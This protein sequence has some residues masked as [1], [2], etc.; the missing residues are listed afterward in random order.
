MAMQTSFFQTIDR[1]IVAVH[2][3]DLY[4]VACRLYS[5]AGASRHPDGGCILRDCDREGGADVH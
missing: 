5:S 3:V 2:A 4:C 1:C